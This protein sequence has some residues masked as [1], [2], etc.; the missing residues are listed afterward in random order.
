MR[1]ALIG[2]GKIANYQMQAVTHTKGIQLVD[3]TTST[4]CAPRSSRGTSTST[5]TSTRC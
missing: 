5:T 3:A 1:I 2:I 4:R